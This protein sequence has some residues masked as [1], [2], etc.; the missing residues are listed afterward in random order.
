MDPR[1]P[2]ACEPPRDRHGCGRLG[3]RPGADWIPVHERPPLRE[4]LCLAG[5]V[6]CYLALISCLVVSVPSIVPVGL[7][8]LGVLLVAWRK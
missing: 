5:A 8:V 7:A 1:L 4:P 3:D 2:R 6:L